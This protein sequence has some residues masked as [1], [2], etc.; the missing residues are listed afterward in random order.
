MRS[1]TCGRWGELLDTLSPPACVLLVTSPTTRSASDRTQTDQ[2]SSIPGIGSQLAAPG[3]VLQTG[4]TLLC[5]GRLYKVVF[6]ESKPRL[7][8]P[9]VRNT[10]AMHSLADAVYF[11]TNLADLKGLGKYWKELYEG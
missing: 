7:V 2:P 5:G 8:N 4:G 3:Q 1:P 6:A 11:H 10:T 9:T